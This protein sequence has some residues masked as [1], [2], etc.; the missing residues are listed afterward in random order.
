MLKATGGLLTGAR[1]SAVAL[2]G[3]L[4]GS[5]VAFQ[6]SGGLSALALGASGRALAGSLNPSGVAALG[7]A[8]RGDG[9][10]LSLARRTLLMTA[11]VHALNSSQGS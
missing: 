9:I 3:G 5:L 1:G 7:D 10:N 8:S 2:A 11:A 4:S 6:A